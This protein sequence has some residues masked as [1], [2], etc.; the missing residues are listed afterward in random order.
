MIWSES[1]VLPEDSGPEDLDDAAARD[2]ADA[3]RRIHRER[4][5][6][7]HRDRHGR[8]VAEAA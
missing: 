2:A 7:D 5:G 3:E 1:V 6:G 8:M 4:P